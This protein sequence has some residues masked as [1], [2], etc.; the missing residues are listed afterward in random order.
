MFENNIIHL[1]FNWNELNNYYQNLNK[2]HKEE[3]VFFL[4]D[5]LRKSVYYNNPEA[6]INLSKIGGFMNLSFDS[7]I[8]KEQISIFDQ[9]GYSS[10]MVQN[11]IELLDDEIN[12]Y[13]TYMKT[14]Q[15][16]YPYEPIDIEAYNLRKK[17][18]TYLETYKC[19]RP[20]ELNF[21]EQNNYKK[22]KYS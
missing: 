22:I 10:E 4:S 16:L 5:N 15:W 18:K 11:I 3:F 19:K 2:K 20:S 13:K 6:Y 14:K 9:I 17:F 7:K 21:S 8:C 1:L 12:D